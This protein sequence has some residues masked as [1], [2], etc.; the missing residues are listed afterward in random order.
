[1]FARMSLSVKFIGILLVLFII[2]TINAGIIFSVV[3]QQIVNGRAINL[4]GRQRMLS[5]KMSKEAF[6]YRMEQ[7]EAEREKIKLDL[8]KTAALFDNTLLGLL[9]GDKSQRL[10]AVDNKETKNKLLEVQSLWRVFFANITTCVSSEYGSSEME[11]ALAQIQKT[12]VHLLQTMNQAVGLYESNN[13]LDSIKMIQGVLFAIVVTITGLALYFVR[14]SIVNPL[15]SVASILG[16]SSRNIDNLSSSVASA[17]ESIAEGSSSQAAATE[18]SAASLE[19]ITSMTRQNADNT[20][21]ANSNMQKTKSTAE[22]AYGV[23][24]EMNA[25]MGEILKASEETQVIVK[26]IDEIAFQTNLLSLNAAVEAARAGEAGAGFAVVADEVR[27]LALRSA[28]SAKNTAALI[29]NIVERIQGG[30]SLVKKATASFREVADGAGKVANLLDE[31]S[32]ANNEQSMGVS[33]ISLGINEMDR[34]TQE[35]V[36]ISEEASATATEMHNESNQL[37]GLVAD[38][39]KLVEGVDDGKLADR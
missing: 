21:L 39:V 25:S 5:Q 26:T 24:E 28:E 35:S 6:T 38:L 9:N 34:L 19:E 10:E 16:E 20:S 27:N 12:N 8:Q 13:N 1:M 2:S 4:A 36:A 18:E 37:G 30:S 33:Q 32:S 23:M 29:E 17:A 15:R 7:D 31:I 22:M 14:T 3:N 11:N